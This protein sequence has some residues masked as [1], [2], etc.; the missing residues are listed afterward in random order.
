M[1]SSATGSPRS[2]SCCSR[3]SAVAP[4][5]ARRTRYR[6]PY[7]R[8]RSRST[9]RSTSG[10]SST[11]RRTGFAAMCAVSRRAPRARRRRGARPGAPR[12]GMS[13]RAEGADG[14]ERQADDEASVAG[15]RAEVQLPAVE[16]D[17]D[18][19]RYRSEEHTSELQSRQYHVC[20]LL[21]EKKKQVL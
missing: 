10:S 13:S 6:S 3:S 7:C 1:S 21:L 5:S 15:R 2:L 19:P 14:G 18:A 16:V 20:R 11:V 8:L 12:G 9:A 17:D 4:L